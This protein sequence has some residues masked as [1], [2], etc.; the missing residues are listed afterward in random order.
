MVIFS[1]WFNVVDWAIIQCNGIVTSSFQRMCG[2]RIF[3]WFMNSNVL[4]P[5]VCYYA[6]E[7][8]ELLQEDVWKTVR[9]SLYLLIFFKSGGFHLNCHTFSF[10]V[11]R[12][13]ATYPVWKLGGAVRLSAES[14]APHREFYAELPGAF[15][16]LTFAVSR[17]N[18]ETFTRWW[19]I[20]PLSMSWTIRISPV[21]LQCCRNADNL[22]VLCHCK[23]L[24]R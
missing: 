21:F 22:T 18:G 20:C 15:V 12:L 9:P 19:C 14:S 17:L 10:K 16:S 8:V 4:W 24:H 13:D 1:R 2:I 5:Y 23:C 7:N 3:W 6:L 11:L